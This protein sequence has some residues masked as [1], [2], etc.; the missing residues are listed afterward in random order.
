MPISVVNGIHLSY[1]E[2]GTGD[3]VVLIAG[4]GALGRVWRAHQVPALNRAGFRAIT[5]DNRG[6]PPSDVCAEGFTL[7]DMV[8]D[9]AG[10]VEHL[11]AVPCRIV[12]ASMGAIIAQELALARPDLVTQAVLMATRG[13]TDA[14][15]GAVADAELELFDS[16]TALP[17]RYEA[18][19]QVL[20]GFSRR[21]LRDEQAVRDWLDLFELS[22][23]SASLSR[24]QLAVDRLPDRLEDYRRIDA[25]CL[26]LGF[27]DDLVTPPHLGREVAARIPRGSYREIPGCGHHGHLEDPV[28]VNAAIIEFFGPR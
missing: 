9:V 19:F 13:R 23:L 15:S 8:A 16:G 6:V 26:V 1:E 5:L 3:P 22:P 4:T 24:S 20:R 28:A 27:A 7:A 11:G 25:E 21:T 14:L 10:L 12:G 18:M 2:H 17:P